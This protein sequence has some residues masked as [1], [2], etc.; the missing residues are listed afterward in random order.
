MILRVRCGQSSPYK[1]KS[2]VDTADQIQ[3]LLPAGLRAVCGTRGK[4][5]PPASRELGLSLIGTRNRVLL[6][7]MK[8]RRSS[9]LAPPGRLRSSRRWRS[10]SSFSSVVTCHRGNRATSKISK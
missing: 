1:E 5:R 2:Q 6:R 4:T 7:P 3:A 9:V 8:L 10:L